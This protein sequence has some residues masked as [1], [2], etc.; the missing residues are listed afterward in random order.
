MMILCDAKIHN[1][2]EF[3]CTLIVFFHHAK[4]GMD[5]SLPHFGKNRLRK[6]YWQ[7]QIQILLR[8]VFGGVIYAQ[9]LSI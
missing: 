2:N 7:F 8:V 3:D 6:Q 5:R 9:T 1:A 4:Q